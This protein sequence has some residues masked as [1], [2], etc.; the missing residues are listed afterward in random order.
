MAENLPSVSIDSVKYIHEKKK[1]CII[2]GIFTAK[3]DSALDA[4]QIDKYFKL[5]DTFNENEEKI[6]ENQRKIDL[7]EK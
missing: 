6:E 7:Q 1:H 4:S 5:L 2:T 3:Q